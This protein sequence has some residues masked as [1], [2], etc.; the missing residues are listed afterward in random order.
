MESDAQ[1]K[2]ELGR[3]LN[4]VIFNKTFARAVMLSIL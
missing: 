4:I 3:E 2:W 1:K